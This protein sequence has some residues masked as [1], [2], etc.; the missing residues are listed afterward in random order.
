LAPNQPDQG[1]SKE[2][3]DQLIK[4]YLDQLQGGS[5]NNKEEEQF[6]GLH[7]EE[8]E[9]EPIIPYDQQEQI[10]KQV[11]GGQQLPDE[12]YFG[13]DS[14]P[15]KQGGVGEMAELIGAGLLGGLLGSELT[16]GQNHHYHGQQGGAYPYPAGYPG[17]SGYY[18]TSAGYPYPA[19]YPSSPYYPAYGSGYP[20]RPYSPSY[21]K[22]QQ[23]PKY[24][25]SAQRPYYPSYYQQD[26][27][28]PYYSP[29]GV[30]KQY[31]HQSPFNMPP[32][33]PFNVQ[34]NKKLIDAIT[35]GRPEL[36]RNGPLVGYLAKPES[37][38]ELA[39]ILA[40]SGLPQ[41]FTIDDRQMMEQAALKDGPFVYLYPEENKK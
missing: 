34:L 12:S 9:L 27:Y 40:K 16:G 24:H 5:N 38:L 2:E 6:F 28:Y 30:T 11:L 33:R 22:Q 41:G 25:Q 3:I 7:K 31:Q 36:S 8:Q 10:L 37:Q 15:V 39:S 23:G 4:L 17:A 13:G 18:P 32:R 1:Y 26:P 29:Q 21:P 14:K 20:N 19:V 35:G